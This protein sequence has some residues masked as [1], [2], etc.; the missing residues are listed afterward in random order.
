MDEND[1]G[2]F[3]I[4]WINGVPELYQLVSYMP[5][6]SVIMQKL[7]SGAKTSFAVGS[8][9]AHEFKKLKLPMLE[10]IPVSMNLDH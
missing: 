7:Y 6:P 2:Q 9:L 4:Q 1:V 8:L 3:Y 10:G 5:H